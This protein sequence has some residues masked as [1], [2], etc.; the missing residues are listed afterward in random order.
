MTRLVINKALYLTL[1]VT[2]DGTK[3]I[4]SMWTAEIEGAIFCL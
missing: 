3:D 2:W 4:H 1:G